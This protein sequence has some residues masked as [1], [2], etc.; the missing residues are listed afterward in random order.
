MRRRRPRA[1]RPAD[2][3]ALGL[4]FPHAGQHCRSSDGGAR[5]APGRVSLERVYA[6]TSLAV[7]Q[8]TAAELAERVRGHWAIENREHHVRDVT[9]GE[10]A[11]RVRT[12]NAPRAMASLRNLAIGALR[13]AGRDNIAEGLRHHGRDMARPLATLGLT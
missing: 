1:R 12:G 9:F 7:H 11:S 8:A 10:D 4:P 6:V 5:C 13:L 2:G 3:R